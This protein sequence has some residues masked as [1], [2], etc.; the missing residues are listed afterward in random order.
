MNKT[1]ILTFLVV[2]CK[3]TVWS[4]ETNFAPKEYIEL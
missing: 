3:A 2:N 1:E 4:I